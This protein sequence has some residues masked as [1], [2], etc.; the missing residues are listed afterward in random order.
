[1]DEEIIFNYAYW[2][3]D[4]NYIP[5]MEKQGL[6]RH[7]INTLCLEQSKEKFKPVILRE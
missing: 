7:F 5:F 6:L 1:M 4:L 2:F 3:Q